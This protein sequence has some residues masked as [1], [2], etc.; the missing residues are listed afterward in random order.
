LA[1]RGISGI[2]IVESSPVVRRQVGE[3]IPPDTRLLLARLGLWD[4]FVEEGHAP[5]LGSCSSWDSDRLGYNDFVV[6]PYGAGWHLDRDRFDAFL[7]G[8]A[9]AAGATII[10]GRAMVGCEPDGDDGFRLQLTSPPPAAGHGV[11]PPDRQPGPVETTSTRFVVDAT[12]FRS[13]FA[14][15]Q[16]AVVVPLD[17]LILVYGF[18]EQSEASSRSQL[19]LL[20][21]TEGG[22]WYSAPLPD[23]R[24]A[25]ALGTDRQT[26]ASHR[27]DQSRQWLSA[28][29]QTRHTARRLHGCR[30]LPGPLLVRTAPS[31]RLDPVGG[32]RWLAVGDAACAFDPLTSQGIYKALSDAL[33]ASDVVVAWLASGED[34]TA[35]YCT[36]VRERFDQYTANRNYLYQLERRWP[37]S[38]FWQRRQGCGAVPPPLG[39]NNVR[40][41]SREWSTP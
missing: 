30:L 16:G 33:A 20:E 14:R 10:T 41:S 36:S 2:R 26:N 35:A 9:T 23:G 28:L 13:A 31:Y 34:T 40:S 19:T 37:Q 1:R 29:L 8:Q 12:G 15:R 11:E 7:R 38:P 24:V 3:T 5:C 22:W 39:S 25:V 4:Q 18:F 17:R 32:A 21:A 6:N 27:V